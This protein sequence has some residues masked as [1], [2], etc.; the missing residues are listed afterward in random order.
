MKVL[1]TGAFGNVGQSTIIAL[2]NKGYSIRCFDLR[3]DRNIKIAKKMQKRYP[4]LEIFWGDIRRYEAVEKAVQGVQAIIHLAAIIPPLSEIKPDFA[5]T[6]NVEGS[7]N[8][9]K[10]ALK[11]EPKPRFI[12]TSS[13]SVYGRK[14][15][16]A[17][18]RKISDSFDPIEEYGK[19]K[20][21]IEQELQ[22]TDLPWTILRLGAVT[23]NYAPWNIPPLL[24]EIPLNQRIEVVH[25]LDVGLAC[26]N[27]VDAPV[28]G[29]VL[30]IG[31]G[32]RCQMLQREFLLKMLGAMGISMLPDEAFKVATNKEDW[33]HL[34]W[35]D[36]EEA[37]RLLKYQ[38]HSLEDFTREFKK[39]IRFQRFLVTL[40]KPIVK[41]I[42]LSK[43]PYYKE[44]K[45]LKRKRRVKT[46]ATQ[47]NT[48]KT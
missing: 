16:L 1:V 21:T 19:H 37:Q 18:P 42:I 22:Q 13:V 11:Q 35:M 33:Y 15:D 7:R 6:V 8:L 40:F 32:K 31:G 36:T 44:Y 5:Y 3:N 14:M 29:K 45:K 25:T 24:F 10:A 30:H 38:Q 9:I 28:E 34:D 41:S 47:I 23:P 46:I 39:K 17:P 2:S 20:I 12:F 43:S 48:T 4:A 27:A 26:A